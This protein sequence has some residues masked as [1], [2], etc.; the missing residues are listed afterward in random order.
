MIS[1]DVNLLLSGV[2]TLSKED[3]MNGATEAQKVVQI[4]TKV[5]PK[6]TS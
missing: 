1:E 6:C 4:D 5:V 2:K 3:F